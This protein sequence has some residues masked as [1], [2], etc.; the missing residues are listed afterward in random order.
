MAAIVVG[1]VQPAEVEAMLGSSFGSIPRRNGG[2]RADVQV[3]PHQGTRYVSLSDPEQTASSVSIMVKRPFDAL[4][5]AAAYRRSLLRSLALSMINDRLAE[6]ARQPGAPF[7][8]ASVGVDHLGRALEAATIGARVQDGRIPQGLAGISQ[9]IQ[10]IRQIRVWCGGTGARQTRHAGRLRACVQRTQT[11][12][13][14]GRSSMSSS[15][16]I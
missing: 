2:R 5:S 6:I 16:T 8:A 12:Q 4:E 7:L 13:T 3:P 14:A 10:R 1:D 9:E 11:G 15:V